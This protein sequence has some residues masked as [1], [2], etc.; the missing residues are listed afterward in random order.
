[1]PKLK[2]KSKCLY[3][4]LD[5]NIPGQLF[6]SVDLATFLPPV[7]CT[8]PPALYPGTDTFWT[9]QPLGLPDRQV[10]AQNIQKNEKDV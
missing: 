8:R 1:M 2:E 3:N 6:A 9:L 7:M 5:P 4:T 10:A